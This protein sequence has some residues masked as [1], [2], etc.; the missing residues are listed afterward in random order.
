ME[1][2]WANSDLKSDLAPLGMSGFKPTA[3]LSEP[4]PTNTK[5]PML[6]HSIQLT[7][8]ISKLKQCF[9]HFGMVNKTDMKKVRG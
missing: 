8:K 7:K 9:Y 1:N 5:F 6:K 2:F 4:S 3:V